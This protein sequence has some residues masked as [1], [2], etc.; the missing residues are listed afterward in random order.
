MPDLLD[1]GHVDSRMKSEMARLDA[2]I[3]ESK[4]GVDKLRAR[5]RGKFARLIIMDWL[6]IEEEVYFA[7]EEPLV[8]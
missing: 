3:E 1:P 5:D 8:V 4:R 6:V 2:D 7:G